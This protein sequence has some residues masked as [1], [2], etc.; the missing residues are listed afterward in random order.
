LRPD[1]FEQ[2][3]RDALR[4]FYDHTLSNRVA[5]A[6]TLSLEATVWFEALPEYAEAVTAITEKHALAGA[7]AEAVNDEKDY[8]FEMLQEAVRDAADAPKVA[9]IEI[10]PAITATAPESLFTTGDNFVDAS[11]KL[12]ARKRLIDPTDEIMPP[13]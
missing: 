12:V 13:G 6:D 11:C 2:I 1:L 8:Q 3:A 4:P 9:S 7:A 5:A 10:E